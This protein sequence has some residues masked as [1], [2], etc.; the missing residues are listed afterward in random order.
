MI[1]NSAHG[2]T[3][4]RGKLC[5]GNIKEL[6]QISSWPSTQNSDGRNVNMSYFVI[7]RTY[8]LTKNAWYLSDMIFL[9]NVATERANTVLPMDI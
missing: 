2:P 4:T 6:M 5:F 3:K 8:F 1:F 9:L 7:S